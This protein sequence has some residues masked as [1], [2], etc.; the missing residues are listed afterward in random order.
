M[1]SSLPGV[2]GRDLSHY[3]FILCQEVPARMIDKEFALGNIS[4][5]KMNLAGPA[6][7][8]VMFADNIMLFAKANRR[9][10]VVLNNCLETYCKWSGQ[11]VNC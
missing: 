2:L 9:E 10:A 7:T 11:L 6:F 4:G 8:H 1:D 5:V 3:L